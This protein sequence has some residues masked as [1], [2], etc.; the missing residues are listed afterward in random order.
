MDF[1]NSWQTAKRIAGIDDL[2]FHDL[3]ASAI[4]RWQT[5]GVPLAIASKIAGHSDTRTTAKY[6]T[7]ADIEIV[8]TLAEAMN[9]RH[10]EGAANVAEPAFV[11]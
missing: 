2:R 4:T 10:A 9:R 1:K 3:R 7:S 8:Q 5:D 11:N 6:Y